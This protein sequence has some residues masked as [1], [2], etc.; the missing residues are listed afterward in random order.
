MSDQETKPTEE[1]GAPRP[2]PRRLLRSTDDRM[3]AGVAA[4]L[5]R[6]FNVDPVIVRIGF[7]V[8]IFLGGLGALAYL[9]LALFVP[10]G[11]AAGNQ[12][13]RPPVERSRTLALAAGT[14]LLI[15]V[16]SLGLF[17]GNAWG[18]GWFIW[19]PLLV[20]GVGV[21]LYVLIRDRDR[22][23]DRPA[24]GEG[25]RMSG[26]RIALTLLAAVIATGA[27]AVLAVASAWAGAT[28]HGFAVAAILTATGVLLIASAFRGGARWLLLPAAFLALPLATVAAADIR[29]GDGVG[30]RQYSPRTAAA[31]PADGYELGIG[32]LVVDLRDLGWND[33]TVVDLDVDL[34]IG[35]ALVIVPEDVC[36]SGELSAS[37]GQLDLAGTRSDG[38][39]PEL[40]ADD[41]AGSPPRLDLVGEADFAEFRVINDDDADADG[42]HF[43]DS[44][45]GRDAQLERMRAACAAE[46]RAPEGPKVAGGTG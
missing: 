41:L 11:D 15:V 22:D 43:G 31:I 6:Y 44:Y 38:F 34:G 20:I 45:G 46:P 30:E 9:A 13:D 18:H 42:R 3:L 40:A 36:V 39:D 26:P 29:F 19:P 8:S 14:G 10:A 24:A 12:I 1:L 28:G 37:G 7:A 17:D 33:D 5:G 16:L 25:R 4:G 32:R 27:L 2:G 35:Q 21:G 23:R